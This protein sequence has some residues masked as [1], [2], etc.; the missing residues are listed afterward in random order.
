[1]CVEVDY[2]MESTFV[3]TNICLIILGL[4]CVLVILE[5]LARKRLHIYRVLVRPVLHRT[6]KQG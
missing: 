6:S 5:R 2:Q 4:K 3:E 1:M